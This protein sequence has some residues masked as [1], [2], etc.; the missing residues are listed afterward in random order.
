MTETEAVTETEVVTEEVATEEA[1][2]VGD[3]IVETAT[4][5]GDFSTLL[6]AVEAA[7]LV[8][9]LT[10]PGPLTVFAPTDAAFDALPADLLA[11]LMDDPDLL[12][13]VLL[14]HV[15][16][17]RIPSDRMRNRLLIKS[18]QGEF[19]RIRIQDGNVTAN[20]ANV[21]T[22]DV[23]AS[24]GVIHVIDSV[25]VPQ[26]VVDAL[27][28]MTETATMTE[29]ESMTDT[30]AM[31]ETTGM[32]ESAA[33]TE[34]EVMTESVAMTDTE[35]MTET[36]AMAETEAMTE[37]E[38]VA[39]SAAMTETE[40]MTEAEAAPVQDIVAT[41]MAVDDF[42]T[43]VTAV[44]AAGLVDAL[45][46]PGPYTVFAPTNDAFAALPEGALDALLADPEALKN[47]LFYHVVPGAIMA[48]DITDGLVA[49]TLQGDKVQ[50]SLSGDSVLINDAQITTADIMASNGVIHVIDSVIL[51]PADAALVG[52]PAAAP[53]A[54]EPPA[55]EEAP[56]VAAAPE[57]MP[58]TGVS[59]GS[60]NGTLPVVLLVIL[61]LFA[62]AFVTRQRPAKR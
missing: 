7:G 37:T 14:Y 60:A 21:V 61:G 27:A 49:T 15:V 39:D 8:G 26:A 44:Q 50:F 4:A 18:E 33:M 59:F 43:L 42:S 58:Q 62:C 31:T 52:E 51:P 20:D 38:G 28:A 9:A 57:Q 23:E 40:V 47:V 25:L 35:V 32:A 2:P 19:I 45:Q 3:D 53:A 29:T 46:G 1:A 56:A 13:Q 11:D 41:A 5:A 30:T 24:N 48:A 34:T 6:S 17:S 55:T 54:E 36:T 16:S 12:Q 22:P 10:S